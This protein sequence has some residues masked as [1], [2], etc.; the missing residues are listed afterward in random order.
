MDPLPRPPEERIEDPRPITEDE[1]ALVEELLPRDH[2]NRDEVVSRG[3]G[4]TVRAFRNAV[5]YLG[6]PGKTPRVETSKVFTREWVNAAGERMTVTLTVN[7]G[8]PVSIVGRKNGR[9]AEVPSMAELSR[10]SAAGT[11]P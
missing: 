3:V 4:T 11:D 10:G 1:L 2:P 6:W 8:V 5:L 7:R 9:L